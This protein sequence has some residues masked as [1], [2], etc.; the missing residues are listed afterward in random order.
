VNQKVTVS[1]LAA[2][3]ADGLTDRQIANRVGMKWT[4]IRDRRLGLGL[5]VN[6]EVSP[7]RAAAGRRNVGVMLAALR[8]KAAGMSVD[9]K[10]T[11]LRPTAVAIA[12]VLLD[13]SLTAKELVARLDK[14]ESGFSSNVPAGV[15]G[16]RIYYLRLLRGLIGRGWV[17]RFRPSHGDARKVRYMLTVSA[18]EAIHGSQGSSQGVPGDGGDGGQPDLRQDS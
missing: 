7:A 4:S 18:L 15:G 10:L 5:R 13:G 9:Y 1:L 14:F 11:G 6:R 12:L 2:M 8:R 17:V 16:T 3:V